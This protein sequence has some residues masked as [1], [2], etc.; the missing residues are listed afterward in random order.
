MDESRKVVRVY[1]AGSLINWGHEKAPLV[2]QVLG[3]ALGESEYVARSGIFSRYYFNF[4]QVYE[5][6]DIEP[7]QIREFHDLF[8]EELNKKLKEIKAT[9]LGLVFPKQG[10]V[11]VVQL[12]GVIRERLQ[13]PALIIHID[14]RLLRNQ[15]SFKPPHPPLVP[16]DRVLLLSDAATSGASIYRAA[17]IV[18]RF[19]AQCSHAL[20]LFDRLQGAQEKLSMKDIDLDRLI[21][22]NFFKDV[23]DLKEE[24]LREEKPAPRLGFESAGVLM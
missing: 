10:P 6:A 5:N 7:Q 3:K 14:E 23:K 21:D 17:L 8:I 4:D 12:R 9:H 13:V 11:G 22:R 16:A 18:R 2:R 20:V 1:Q 19:G 24:S 15:I